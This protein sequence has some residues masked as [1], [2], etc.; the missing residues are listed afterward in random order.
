MNENFDDY[1]GYQYTN[2]LKSLIGSD[3]CGYDDKILL[4]FMNKSQIYLYEYDKATG[5]IEFF[6][7]DALC[8]HLDDRCPA[9]NVKGNLEAADGNVYI[10]RDSI[11]GPG[12]LGKLN[13]DFFK[14]TK[15]TDIWSFRHWDGHG[16][17]WLKDGSLIKFSEDYKKYEVITQDIICYS[18][19]IIDGYM[20]FL[21]HELI[22]ARFD[23]TKGPGAEIEIITEKASGFI[24]D[25]RH[26]Y[27]TRF[28][29]ALLY[30]CDMDG[31]NKIS[32]TD[33]PVYLASANYDEK[34]IYFMEYDYFNPELENNRRFYRMDRNTPGEPEYLCTLDQYAYM[35]YTIPG[36][37]LLIFWGVIPR[38]VPVMNDK[39]K[40]EMFTVTDTIGYFTMKKDGTDR[41]ELVFPE[42]K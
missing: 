23:L 37:D 22:I 35:L 4:L 39:G 13:K 16:Y 21:N 5:E 7:K 15:A 30:R 36:F 40:M 6:C 42:P 28:D 1:S 33:F 11:F 31:K 17:S 8:D 38:E 27:Y 19:V 24:T 14:P 2:M 26:I 20:Y 10:L 12:T 29:G 32:V 25:G 18:H 9:G 41:R 34:Y 3:V